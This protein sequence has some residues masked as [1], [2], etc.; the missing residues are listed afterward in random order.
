MVELTEEERLQYIEK[1]S[2][3]IIHIDPATAF[4]II[5]DI[6]LNLI[7]KI[8]PEIG[9]ILDATPIKLICLNR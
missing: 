5:L 9:H 4:P 6:M 3:C 1:L 8:E 7:Q 2:A